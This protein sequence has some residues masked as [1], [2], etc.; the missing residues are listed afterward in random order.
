MNGYTNKIRKLTQNL[1]EIDEANKPYNKAIVE[2][3]NIENV[4]I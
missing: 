2:L 3:R 4:D 1:N